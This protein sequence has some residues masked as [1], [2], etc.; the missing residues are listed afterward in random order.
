MAKNIG[1]GKSKTETNFESLGLEMG[2]NH[3][4]H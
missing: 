1:R 2:R 3:L 4:K